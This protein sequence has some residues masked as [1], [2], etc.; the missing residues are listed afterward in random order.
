[1]FL[2]PD[3]KADAR[4]LFSQPPLLVKVREGERMA[5]HTKSVSTPLNPALPR[6]IANLTVHNV[7]RPHC[8]ILLLHRQTAPRSVKTQWQWVC[9]SWGFSESLHIP[10]G[11]GDLSNVFN[12]ILNWS[13]LVSLTNRR[14]SRRLC[15][16]VV[17]YRWVP[18]ADSKLQR[19]QHG[20]Y[21]SCCPTCPC[22]KVHVKHCSIT[23]INSILNGGFYP[24][25]LALEARRKCRIDEW[26]TR[27]A[28]PFKSFIKQR[29]PR[30][31][32]KKIL[33]WENNGNN[34][35]CCINAPGDASFL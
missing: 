14:W 5:L 19:R 11:E 34:T 28:G 6:L 32:G 7:S 17:W 10:F 33:S 12:E 27:N 15:P 24:A 3:S 8:L 4:H 22:L 26:H 30:N 21:K 1:M 29:S 20:T 35:G 23:G 31:K 13:T 25:C 18:P 2:Q 9:P 16:G